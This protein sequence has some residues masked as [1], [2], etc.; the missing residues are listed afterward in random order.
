METSLD[1]NEFESFFK[2]NY[3]FLC[4]TS[5]QIVKDEDVAKD[6]VQEFFM[7]LWQRRGDVVIRSSFRSYAS[8]A[9]RNLSLLHLKRDKREQGK[10]QSFTDQELDEIYLDN[11]EELLLRENIDLRVMKMVD[12]L[13]GD[14]KKIFMSYVVDGLS[15]QQISEKYNISIN[16]VKTQ[17]KRAYAALKAQV[18]DDPLSVIVI[19]ILMSQT[20]K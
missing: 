13:P 14:R 5:F 12:Q 9:V 6:I 8:G 15:Y 18:S 17:M 1:I 11:S 10:L 16:T 2:S 20:F 3:K 4:V 19:S 7:S